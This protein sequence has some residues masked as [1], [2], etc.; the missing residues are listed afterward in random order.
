MIR[1]LHSEILKVTTTRIWWVLAIVLFGYVGLTAGGMA[2]LF[3]T[4]MPTNGTAIPQD[5]VPPV[6]Y[7]LATSVGYAFP[8]LF[9]ALATTGEF[10]HKTLT[11]TFLATPRRSVVLGAKAA[12]SALGGA[13]YGVVGVLATAGIGAAVLAAMGRPTLLDQGDTWAMLARSVLS[14]TLWAVVG[15]GLGVLVRNQVV[16]IVSVL[17]FT[18]FVQPLLILAGTFW[19]WSAAVVRFLPGAA[20]DALVGASIFQV[21]GGG[22]AADPLEWWQGGLV[23]GGYAVLFLILGGLT[24]WRRDVT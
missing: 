10:R 21:A 7:S 1:S 13:V 23:L 5:A 14:M 22:G 19:E 16:V 3:S 17:A 15:T 8:I 4:D 24:S 20:S 6:V 9:G 12:V 11:P 2:A 18:Q